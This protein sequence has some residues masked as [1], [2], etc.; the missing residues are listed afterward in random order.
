MSSSST[1]TPAGSRLDGWLGAGWLGVAAGLFDA[2]ALP[3]HPVS[4]VVLPFS[5][6]LHVVV[7]C[8]LFAL[9]LFCSSLVRPLLPVGWRS[10]P[11]GLALGFVGAALVGFFGA[12][13]VTTSSVALFAS[14]FGVLLGLAAVFVAALLVLVFG[15]RLWS[16]WT[17][18]SR[19][20]SGFGRTWAL[21]GLLL[22]L[23]I[24]PVLYLQF[25]LTTTPAIGDEEPSTD[26]GF[27]LISLD[28]L[29]GD[30]LTGL[31]YGRPTT[32]TLDRLI[33]TGT[34]YSRA[35]IQQPCSGPGHACMLSG[36][37]SLTH[38]VVANAH[39]LS[40]SV[41][42]IAERLQAEGFRTA[43]FI[44]NF[45][46]ESR[47]GFDQGFEWFI[48]QYRAS[49][50]ADCNPKFLLRGLSLFHFWH[51][52]RYEPGQWNNDTIDLAISW[53]RHRP[54]GDFFLFLHIM[55]PHGPYDPP[56]ELRDR[57]YQP[58]G[59]PVRDDLAL[60]RR[61]GS[62]TEREVAALRDLYDGDVALA[63]RKVGRLLTTL[64]DLGL[65]ANSLLVT[66][67]DHGEVLYEKDRVFDHG[68]IHEGNLHVP[69]IFNFPGQVP[70]GRVWPEP[71]SATALVPTVFALLG[72]D[73]DD[74]ASIDFYDPL[75]LATG[76][77]ETDSTAVLPPLVFTLTGINSLDLAAAVGERYKIVADS[78]GITD[79]YD[80]DVD[81]IELTNLWP[82]LGA[83][84]TRLE[85]RELA[86][87]MYGE[88][89]T[90]LESCRLEAV[91][92]REQSVQA[93]DRETA[94]R[95]EALGYVD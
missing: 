79:L 46:L 47:F 70:A 42:T 78:S 89:Q 41:L 38:G 80:L 71:V 93:V 83:D 66:T 88:L 74:Q 21:A 73:Y 57:F 49:Q 16:T 33:T 14:R 12:Y 28:A 17:R 39:V 1:R 37:P 81:P 3:L 31:G 50:L 6:F 7:A 51:R 5:V 55:D 27:I 85:L 4:L 67:A 40:D 45:Y 95:L 43:A 72:I 62:L 94:R 11:S 15:S 32:P 53:L 36:L 64:S 91:G 23:L 59:A 10:S 26:R 58:D 19:T 56:P 90:W 60:R 65:L 52:L 61:M 69:L 35:Y 13:G 63:D 86:H 8:L 75:P 30:R 87:H 92:N 76:Y 84:G 22:A 24:Y 68:L 82:D 34:T 44:N 2:L 25:A 20:R 18:R 48:N 9:G 77:A 29:R 54:A